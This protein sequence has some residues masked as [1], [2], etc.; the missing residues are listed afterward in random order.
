MDYSD[1]SLLT[2][3]QREM[4]TGKKEPS[5]R[6]Q[7]NRRIR[8]R[9]IAGMKDLHLLSR[10]WEKDEMEKIFPPLFAEKIPW[11]WD[12]VEDTEGLP[13]ELPDTGASAV[14]TIGLITFLL[15][16]IEANHT[17]YD[18][19]SARNYLAPELRE[20]ERLI[21]DGVTQHLAHSQQYD[22]EV[23]VSIDVSRCQ[24]INQAE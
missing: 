22:C 14:Y 11:Y 15:R 4:L 7:M 3:A 8:K 20:F 18:V 9:I 17:G 19:T 6:R 24:K 13:F 21:E 12:Q 1:P 16:L 23:R 2:K 5:N 10:S